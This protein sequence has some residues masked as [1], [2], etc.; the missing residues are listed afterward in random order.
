MADK[1]KPFL[2]MVKPEDLKTPIIDYEIF[3]KEMVDAFIENQRN[4]QLIS[5]VNQL[6][7]QKEYSVVKDVL[8]ANLESNETPAL[9]EARVFHLLMMVE[10]LWHLDD[11]P[12]TMAWIEQ[13]LDE[14]MKCKDSEISTP[15]DK[16]NLLRTL[17]C[18][19]VM[20]D[21]DF[22]PIEEKSRLA[23]NLL[24]LILLQIDGDEECGLG[25]KTVLP[26][27]L[28]HKLIVFE[29]K[30]E[31]FEDDV[32]YSVNFL[33]SAHDY[34][35]PLSLCTVDG[36]KILTLMVT[37]V[38]DTLFKG[39][40]NKAT[41]DQ[42][43]RNI[44]QALF[45]LYAHPSKKSKARHLVDHNI[46]NVAFTWEGCLKPYVYLRP[47]KLPEY[48]DLKSASISSE[49]LTFFKRI[50]ALVP[51]HYR[52]HKRAKLV[53]NYLMNNSS[54]FPTFEDLSESDESESEI[55]V[56]T[57]TT[58]KKG[59]PFPPVMVDL[60]Y[61][62]ADYYIKNS[63]FKLAIDFYLIDLS[64]NPQR[65]D[66]WVSLSLSLCNQLESKI[67]EMDNT[68]ISKE[69]IKQILN[70]ARAIRS[71]FSKCNELAP[72]NTTV[73]IESGNFGYAM[74]AFC[75]RQMNEENVEN[76][77]MDLFNS[78]EELRPIFADFAL[79]NYDKAVQ[80][81][82]QKAKD[83]TIDDNEHDER[84][85]SYLMTGKIKE[86]QKKPL[87]ESL[88]LYLK[89]MENLVSQGATVPKKINFNS[90][91]EWTLE[92][93]EVYFR[94]HASI[95]KLELKSEH[96]PL[97]NEKLLLLEEV[98]QRF[99]TV[100]N[101]AFDGLNISPGLNS[102]IGEPAAKVPRNDN[103]TVAAII[104]SET[105]WASLSGACLKGLELTV[106]RFPQ[107]FKALHLLAQYY[108]KSKRHKDL[109]KARKYL[110]GCNDNGKSPSLFGER[111]GNN[112]FSG[113]WRMPL[114]EVDR[115][116][117]F[118]THMGK[119]INTLLEFSNL[120]N[121]HGILLEVA[122]QLRKAPNSDQ[123][124]LYEKQR[125]SFGKTA[126]VY[127]KKAVKAKVEAAKSKTKEA[128]LSLLLEIHALHLKL[129]KSLGHAKDDT[130]SA[131]MIELYKSISGAA[132]ASFEEVNNFCNKANAAEKKPNLQQGPK[133]NSEP[134]PSTSSSKNQ[135]NS[136]VKA[137]LDYMNAANYY[138]EL[139]ASMM[140]ASAVSNPQAAS[141]AEAINLM[142]AYAAAS[143][144]SLLQSIPN[145]ISVT[146]TDKNKAASPNKPQ[147]ST[148]GSNSVPKLPPSVTVS[149]SVKP[150]LQNKPTTSAN[151]N[152]AALLAK[153]G[154]NVSKVAKSQQ[155]PTASITK[156]P[157]PSMNKPKLQPNSLLSKSQQPQNK[158]ASAMAVDKIYKKAS[159]VK[160]HHK[161]LPGVTVSRV[162]PEGKVQKPRPPM[163]NI[164]KAAVASAAELLKR[165]GNTSLTKIKP[166]SQNSGGVSK[167]SSTVV[168]D[169]DVICID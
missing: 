79:D 92:L 20:L 58:S 7:A 100:A 9:S 49:T 107:Q 113:I 43:C 120:T 143:Y 114:N 104:K 44:D 106:Q 124:Y 134:K 30:S 81:T 69:T 149:K 133:P 168:T 11:Y 138:N 163:S 167:P 80:I 70:E 142:N 32:P 126:V 161:A 1:M 12:S 130:I 93:L 36:G 28:L 96:F 135:D 94:F 46:N 59:T 84:W 150:K 139:M 68:E 71:S 159:S 121:D 158:T 169:D 8:L 52:I 140:M 118:S 48:D 122:I 29:E 105:L 62:M 6:F 77:S 42:M 95:L 45:C 47:S 156:M 89:A 15:N 101:K 162:T 82:T 51:D 37:G 14:L 115:A 19:L 144:S 57:P 137:A 16:L 117:S 50:I 18:C 98:L 86:K 17:E 109:K 74:L 97:D 53:K 10:S 40:A 145:T 88:E 13:S 27:V 35:G 31:K 60:F 147:A 5:S 76:L 129:R 110:W 73:R 102:S 26:W 22:S 39:V 160:A 63:E 25:E 148:S 131:L 123:K 153:S 67:N 55:A 141:N 85:L 165:T 4:R 103:D 146:K 128:R 87:M 155:Q 3:R 119:C 151:V 23:N 83:G 34:L 90:P 166:M 66:S 41:N 108:I 154:V 72:A 152:K 132:T 164:S 2:D 157:K 125:K 136:Q 112:L 33:C 78:V 127:M 111:K 64:W 21:G 116:G 61:L 91:P 56:V 54:K 38:V 75:G 99:E 24:K 65:L